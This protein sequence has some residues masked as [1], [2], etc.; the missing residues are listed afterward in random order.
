RQTHELAIDLRIGS[1]WR[2]PAPHG[3][4]P[5]FQS[6]GAN[7]RLLEQYVIAETIAR[8]IHDDARLSKIHALMIGALAGL[9]EYDRA[10]EVGQL[11][12]QGAQ[13]TGDTSLETFTRFHLANVYHNRGQLRR[14]AADLRSF[15]EAA[16]HPSYRAGLTWQTSSHRGGYSQLAGTLI[17]LGD[18]DDAV[19]LC[20]EGVRI[21]EAEGD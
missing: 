17:Q 11:A 16:A 6:A 2:G 20:A 3:I 13:A 9:G 14:A 12:L 1:R 8:A 4:G 21:C 15:V 7:R 5:I 19:D 10:I 18:F